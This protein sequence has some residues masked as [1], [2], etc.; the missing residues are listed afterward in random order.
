M[1]IE[2]DEE[3]EEAKTV[4]GPLANEPQVPVNSSNSS[5]GE[6]KKSVVIEEISSTGTSESNWW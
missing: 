5:R 3:E 4:Q 1:Q 2:E 6:A